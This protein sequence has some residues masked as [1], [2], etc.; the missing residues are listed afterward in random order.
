MICSTVSEELSSSCFACSSLRAR[1]Y[2]FGQRPVSLL[3][4]WRK[5]EGE[6]STTEASRRKENSRDRSS[7]RNLIANWTRKS[8]A[9]RIHED[10][11]NV[12]YCEVGDGA[13]KLL[14]FFERVNEISR[15]RFWTTTKRV[16]SDLLC[17]T[18]DCFFRYLSEFPA[19][20][21]VS[22]PSPMSLTPVGPTLVALPVDGSTT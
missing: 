1:T 20:T 16:R 4:T 18:P 5:R 8:M 14:R 6:R 2:A 17:P 10:G 12:D 3:K 21:K 13:R 11:L 9:P 22:L 19:G 7:L 15:V